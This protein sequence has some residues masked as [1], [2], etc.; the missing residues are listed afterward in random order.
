MLAAFEKRF[1]ILKSYKEKSI[2]IPR[3][4][5]WNCAG[6][7]GSPEGKYFGN[8]AEVLRMFKENDGK[9]LSLWWVCQNNETIYS[10]TLLNYGATLSKGLLLY[11]I[12]FLVL[13]YYEFDILLKTSYYLYLVDAHYWDLTH[14]W[15]MKFGDYI[16]CR[17][18]MSINSEHHRFNIS[19][20]TINYIFIVI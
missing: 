7:S 6:E 13:N 8:K 15:A 12:I 5:S 16:R 4:E 2:F 18:K 3:C 10:A 20:F 17:V 11:L 19:A 14:S 9:N 1:L